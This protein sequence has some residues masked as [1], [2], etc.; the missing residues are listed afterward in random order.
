MKVLKVYVYKRVE[1]ENMKLDKDYRNLEF[2]W[3]GGLSEAYCAFLHFMGIIP[4]ASK[5]HMELKEICELIKQYKESFIKVLESIKEV[6][7]PADEFICD[8]INDK[9]VKKITSII[10]TEKEIA[11]ENLNLLWKEYLEKEK[12]GIENKREENLKKYDF[13]LNK[14]EMSNFEEIEEFYKKNI[15][16]NT[17]EI[18]RILKK[19]DRITLEEIKNIIKKDI[20]DLSKI[21]EIEKI[22]INDINYI[23]KYVKENE[24]A[25]SIIIKDK[26]E[27]IKKLEKYPIAIQFFCQLLGKEIGDGINKNIDINSGALNILKYNNFEVKHF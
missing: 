21:L 25:Y 5:K 22:K 15:I 8:F 6:N 9:E 10:E 18:N 1:E 14:E 24:S 2:G 19:Y 7:V 3:S 26:I 27:E 17:E 11:N 20:T 4:L 13:L 12:K 23:E 16:D